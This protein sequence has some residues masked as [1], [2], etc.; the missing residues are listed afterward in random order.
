MHTLTASMFGLTLHAS[1]CSHT[2]TC[3]R[4][5]SHNHARHVWLFQHVHLAPSSPKEVLNQLKVCLL[6]VLV[7]ALANFVA[8]TQA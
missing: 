4:M 1:A 6:C 8:A 3:H 2:G 7:P 5:H